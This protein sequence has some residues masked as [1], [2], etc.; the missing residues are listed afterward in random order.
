MHRGAERRGHDQQCGARPCLGVPAP[1]GKT[2]SWWQQQQQPWGGGA[3]VATRSA[4]GSARL[5]VAA[6]HPKR[7]GAEGD[8]PLIAS[9]VVAPV[10]VAVVAAAAAGVQKVTQ[11]AVTREWLA[12]CFFRKPGHNYGVNRA[13]GRGGGGHHVQARLAINKLSKKFQ[14]RDGGTSVMRLV[15]FLKKNLYIFLYNFFSSILP[16]RY[17]SWFFLFPSCMV[18]GGFCWGLAKAIDEMRFEFDLFD[19]SEK[20]KKK[21]IPTQDWS[22]HHLDSLEMK[23]SSHSMTEY[24]P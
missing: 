17:C 5:Q 12:G 19:Y 10:A 16:G 23:M 2:Q 4:E 9:V 22:M 7:G 11:E 21:K 24:L 3:Q 1:G 20:K 13:G 6:R 8:A 15:I 14:S 18:F